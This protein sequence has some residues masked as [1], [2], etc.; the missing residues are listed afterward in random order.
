MARN[1]QDSAA[2]PLRVP[3]Y[4][5]G[6]I[7]EGQKMKEQTKSMKNR[8][9]VTMLATGLLACVGFLPQTNAAPDIV[10]PPDG[11]YPGFT[12][13]EG[14]QALQN[15]TTGSANTGVGWR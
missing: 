3:G 11:C 6:K 1:D 13:A 15:I 4:A 12:T 7:R 14:C 10:P 2:V 8:N 9:M 5:T